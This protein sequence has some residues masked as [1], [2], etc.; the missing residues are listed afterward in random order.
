MPKDT[1]GGGL[2][3]LQSK[4][5]SDISLFNGGG[6]GVGGDEGRQRPWLG[7]KSG[8]AG[9]P[10]G[11]LVWR[12]IVRGLWGPGSPIPAESESDSGPGFA[13]RVRG[14]LF[15]RRHPRVEAHTV[16]ARSRPWLCFRA[17]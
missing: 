7:I 15:W 4:T 6:V 5:I 8:F 1:S 12:H 11:W 16:L 2:I 17:A 3:S 13:S 14:G 9:C 10:S